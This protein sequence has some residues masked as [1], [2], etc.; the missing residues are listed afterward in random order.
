M[1]RPQ[2][3]QR[4]AARRRVLLWFC[5]AVMAW[6]T[7]AAHADESL[8]AKVK[9]AYVYKFL[10]FVEWPNSAF[11]DASSPIVIGVA[12]DDGVYAELQRVLPGRSVHGRP[13]Q[14]RRM[15]PGESIEALHVLFVGAGLVHGPWVEGLPDR[16]LLVVT[17]APN[18][19]EAGGAIN[20]LLVG[21]RVRFEVSLP[22]VERAGLRLSSRML[23]VAERVVGAR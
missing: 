17:D 20:F 10:S 1:T 19:L 3:P 8:E 11:A 12:G 18:G 9:A 21:G 13:L 2:H 5:S 15:Q 16:P 7:G 22:A 23:G 6:R 4:L 14:V